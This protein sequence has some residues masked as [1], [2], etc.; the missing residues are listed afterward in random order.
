MDLGY[1]VFGCIHRKGGQALTQ[2]PR[3]LVDAQSHVD[4]APGAWGR[5]AWA[6]FRFDGFGIQAFP[7]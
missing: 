4:V 6:L 5:V 7:T 1:Q 2:L 3:A